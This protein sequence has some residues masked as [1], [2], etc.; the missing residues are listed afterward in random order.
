MSDST[1]ADISS[2]LKVLCVVKVSCISEVQLILKAFKLEDQMQNFHP[3]AWDI[4]L[5]NLR[6][7]P[8]KPLASASLDC[9]TRKMPFFIVLT[10]AVCPRELHTLSITKVQLE[11]SCHG[12]V[13]T[14]NCYYVQFEH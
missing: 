7:A 13:L 11:Q 4:V 1:Y 12:V 5:G 3:P 9:V 8:Y 2:V 14:W 6:Q 10:T